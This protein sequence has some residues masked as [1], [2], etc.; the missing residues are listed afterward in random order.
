MARR[1][2]I[3]PPEGWKYGFPKEWDRDDDPLDGSLVPWLL[4]KGYPQTEVDR[5][6]G[7]LRVRV[8]GSAPV[9]D[10]FEFPKL[11]RITKPFELD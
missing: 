6:G 3:D 2:M 1:I 7:S 8:F 4:E 9:D 5:F 10:D 11:G